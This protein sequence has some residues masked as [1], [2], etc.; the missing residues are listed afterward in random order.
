MTRMDQPR[1]PRKPTRACPHCGA[2]NEPHRKVCRNC[3]KPMSA[4]EQ[5]ARICRTPDDAFAAGWHDGAD[6]PPMTPEQR[7]RI[8][9]LLAPYVRPAAEAA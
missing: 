7:T 1:P 2:S 5:V 8:A 4:A 6:D 3:Q 9:A